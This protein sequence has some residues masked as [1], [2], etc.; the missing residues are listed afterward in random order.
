MK[1]TCGIIGQAVYSDFM[2]HFGD[3]HFSS[4]LAPI[5]CSPSP[6]NRDFAIVDGDQPRNV[7][8][9]TDQEMLTHELGTHFDL[10]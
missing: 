6:F 3:G 5:T 7:C 9:R 4:D 10:R 1:L 8:I 2:R